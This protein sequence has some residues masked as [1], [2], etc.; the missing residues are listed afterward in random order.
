MMMS[1]IYK[2]R[3]WDKKEHKKL[4]NFE[5][6]H[7]DGLKIPTYILH[8]LNSLKIVTYYIIIFDET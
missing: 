7:M 8:C 3:F 5:Q 4:N 6:V 2:L 1:T